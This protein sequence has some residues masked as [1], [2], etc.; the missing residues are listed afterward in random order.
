MRERMARFLGNAPF[1]IPPNDSKEAGNCYGDTK[2]KR[3]TG[4]SEKRW[5]NCLLFTRFDNLERNGVHIILIACA[6]NSVMSTRGIGHAG[7]VLLLPFLPEDLSGFDENHQLKL[8]VLKDEMLKKSRLLQD[9]R[10][11]YKDTC[12]ISADCG[13]YLFTPPAKPNEP[14]ELKQMI[15]TLPDDAVPCGFRMKDG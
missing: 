12:V 3:E 7:N 5:S 4:K 1:F 11:R 2:S 14:W 6:L 15:D 8:E 9:I 10:N 13:V